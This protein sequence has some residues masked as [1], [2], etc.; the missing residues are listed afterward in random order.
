MKNQDNILTLFGGET[1]ADRFAKFHAENP[2]VYLLFKRFALQLIEEHKFNKIG[3]RMVIERVRWECYTGSK[4][5]K[6]FK[7]NNYYIAHYARM[8][9]KEFPQ[10]QEHFETRE[11]KVA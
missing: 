3:A 2:R 5:D 4:D 1:I 8:F 9:Q 6:G 7:I 10:Y 11:L